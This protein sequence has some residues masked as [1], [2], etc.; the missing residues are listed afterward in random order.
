LDNEDTLL[1]SKVLVV[2]DQTCV[3]GSHNWTRAGFTRTHELSVI[4]ENATVAAAF[5]KRFDL[6]WDSLPAV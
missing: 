1:H 5:R 6:L 3:V 4:V 2:D